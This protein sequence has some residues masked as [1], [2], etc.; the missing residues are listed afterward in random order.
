MDENKIL[1]PDIGDFEEVDVIDVLVKEGETINIETPIVTLE[2]DK[3]TMDVPSDKIGKVISVHVSV[4]DKI[5]KGSELITLELEKKEISGDKSNARDDELIPLEEQTVEVKPIKVP[6][7]GDFEEV[8]VIEI[9]VK[10]GDAIKKDA[11]IITLE[12]DKATMDLPSPISGRID[13]VLVSVG[14]KVSKDDTVALIIEEQVDVSREHNESI[15]SSELEQQP[16]KSELGKLP[17]KNESQINI[18]DSLEAVQNTNKQAT[19]EPI[20]E[21]TTRASFASPSIRKFARELGV[22]INR[23]KGTGPKNRILKEDIQKF[24]KA[25]LQVSK[26]E[27]KLETIDKKVLQKFGAFEER[28]LTKIQLLTGKNLHGSWTNIPHVF[29]M[30]EI[31]VTELE[32]FR[33]EKA[34][35]LKKHNIKLTLLAFIIKASTTTLQEFPRFNSSLIEEG[36]KIAVKKYHNIGF[37]TNTADGLLVP[38]IKDTDKKGVVEIAQ[39]ISALAELAK[40]KNLKINQMEGGCFTVSNLGAIAG[41]FFTPIINP[42]EVAILGISPIKIKPI[43]KNGGFIPRQI[44]PITLSYDHRV[45]DGVAGAT[46]TKYFGEILSDIRTAIL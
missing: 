17:N 29:Q 7:I 4:G 39:E 46:F 3:A 31:D 8:D 42:N 33:K 12:S 14:D 38:V 43:W 26:S 45:I 11:A 5:S 27:T 40:T 44:L 19:L 18:D 36:N 28:S 2:S 1:C 20:I 10:S 30:D 34:L 21:Q 6:E 37:A 24:V 9:L 22:E 15:P 41:N 16:N 25:R 32:R 13:Q 35:D 23:V